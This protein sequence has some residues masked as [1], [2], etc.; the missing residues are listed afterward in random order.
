MSLNDNQRNLIYIVVAIAAI[1]V[2]YYTQFYGQDD[3]GVYGDLTPL[4]AWTLIQDKSEL[5]I[6]DVRT[7]SEY[8]DGHIEGA[9]LIPVQ[10][11]PDRFDELDKNDELLVY[12]RSGNRSSTAVEILEADG[13]TKIYHLAD[14]VTGWIDAGYPVVQ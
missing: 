6:L 13:F 4:E 1:G 2:V 14:G 8:E 7:V 9:I 12:C 3:Q 10:E 5:V 11:L